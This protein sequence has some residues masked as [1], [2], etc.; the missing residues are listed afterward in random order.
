MTH[1]Q[2]TAV[3]NE[4][5]RQERDRVIAQVYSALKGKRVTQQSLGSVFGV[6]QARIGQ[7]LA[8]HPSSALVKGESTV[9]EDEDA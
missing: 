4:V 6:S 5:R 8:G 7:I 9:I 1:S 2:I 3:L